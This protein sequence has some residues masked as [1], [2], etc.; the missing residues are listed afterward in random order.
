MT[1]PYEDPPEDGRCVRCRNWLVVCGH[2]LTLAEKL[3]LGGPSIDRTS[4][5]V[6]P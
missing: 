5:Q 2:D 3:R 1:E 4:L 6:K